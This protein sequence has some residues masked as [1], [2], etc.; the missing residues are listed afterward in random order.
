MKKI[1]SF[2]LAACLFIPAAVMAAPKIKPDKLFN[3][4]DRYAVIFMDG[5]QRVYLDTDT[6][7]KDYAPAGSLPVIR[8]MTYTEIYA[9]PLDYPAY[10]NNKTVKAVVESEIAAGADL[11]GSDVKYRLLLRRKAAYDTS[12]NPIP[13]GDVEIADNDENAKEIYVNMYRLAKSLD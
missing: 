6:L 5:K 3:Y 2:F 12:G 13:A 9:D 4:Y 10:G 8:G 7:L 1:I 11:Y